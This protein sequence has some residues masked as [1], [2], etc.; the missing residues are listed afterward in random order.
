MEEEF[1]EGEL[2]PG[3]DEIP[4]EA[5]QTMQKP[6]ENSGGHRLPQPQ[7]P[8]QRPLPTFRPID[9]FL[10]SSDEESD[11]PNDDDDN[12]DGAF[13]W[14]RKK[15]RSKPLII[16]WSTRIHGLLGHKTTSRKSFSLLTARLL[17]R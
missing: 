6:M 17:A 4:V 12:E 11:S 15:P 9:K 13:V 7:Q 5:N 14:K 2:S 1:E 16:Y 8:Q 3:A 10:M